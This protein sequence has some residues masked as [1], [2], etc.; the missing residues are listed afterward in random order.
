MIFLWF[1]HLIHIIK[2]YIP[3]QTIYGMEEQIRKLNK[4]PYKNPQLVKRFTDNPNAAS[5]DL[6]NRNPKL[7]DEDMEILADQLKTNRVL[8]ALGLQHNQIGDRGA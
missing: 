8:T 5:L 6:S 1:S 7:G 3:L 2:S 4:E